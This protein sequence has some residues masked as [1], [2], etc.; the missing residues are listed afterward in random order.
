MSAICFSVGFCV[1]WPSGGDIE[2]RLRLEI[3]EGH[4]NAWGLAS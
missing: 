2:A 1:A 4:A 3:P